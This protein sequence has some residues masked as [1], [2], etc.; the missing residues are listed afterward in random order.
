M[1]IDWAPSIQTEY[2]IARMMSQQYMNGVLFDKAKAASYVLEI[3]RECQEIYEE[4]RPHLQL[5]LHKVFPNELKKPYLKTGAYAKGVIEWYGEDVPDI[6]GPFFRIDWVEPDM[7]SREK[8]KKQLLYLG[9]RPIDFTEKGSPRLTTK[10]EYGATVACPSLEATL[11]SL[12]ASVARYYTL[13]HRQSQ[14][15]GWLYGSKGRPSPIRA[16]GRIG[17]GINT[18]GTNTGRGS[19]RVIANIPRVSSV[20]GAEMRGL[21][22]APEGKVLI[23]S[24]LAGLELRCLAHRMKDLTYIDILLNSDIH[25]HNAK[26]MGL[27]KG[28]TLYDQE[29]PSHKNIR[30]LSKKIIYTTLYG[31]GLGKIAETIKGTQKAAKQ[32]KDTLFDNLVALADLVKG[33]QNASKR[34]YLMGLDGR[35]VFM[36]RDD[37]GQVAT[38]KALNTLLQSDGAIIAKEWLIQ[39]DKEIY[40]CNKNIDTK[41]LIWYHDEVLVETSPSKAD[42]IGEQ[43]VNCAVKAGESLGLRCPLDADYHIGSSWGDVH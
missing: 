43:I 22:I 38:H 14:M 11:G 19:H 33:V 41:Q 36:R 9:W 42:Q 40:T 37:R 28:D 39:Q 24:D 31:G 10:D 4:V 30:D 3:E 34:G 29:N 8:F 26:L 1:I 23:G 20:Y 12:G 27:I 13:R 15:K 5:E 16:D 18:L 32:L 25:W 21:F 6:G 2:Y 7:N 35:K 17:A